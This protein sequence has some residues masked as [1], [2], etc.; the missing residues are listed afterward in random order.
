M[1]YWEYDLSTRL[2]PGDYGSAE[3]D[4]SRLLQQFMGAKSPF[5]SFSEGAWRPP[6]D[7]YETDDEFVVVIEVH[8]ADK[9][10]ISLEVRQN[11]LV[12]RGKR[13]HDRGSCQVSYHQVEIKFGSFEAQLRLPRGLDTGR[14]QAKYSDGCLTVTV[15]K[16]ASGPTVIDID[17]GD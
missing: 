2:K 5:H 8:G 10:S 1:L 13:E 14:A 15:P 11:T 4:M 6:T 3:A 16:R 12:V 17:S 7:I 9:K